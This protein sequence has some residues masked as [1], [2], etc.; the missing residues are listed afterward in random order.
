MADTIA[1]RPPPRRQWLADSA[2]K[3]TGTAVG[4]LALQETDVNEERDQLES[5]SDDDQDDDDEL[6]TQ[7]QAQTQSQTQTPRRSKAASGARQTRASNPISPA[8]TNPARESVTGSGSTRRGAAT[9]EDSAQESEDEDG[10]GATA[11]RRVRP[12]RG[13]KPAESSSEASDED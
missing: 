11:G 10:D 5:D 3:W 1:L 9:Q 12:K 8:R 7:T 2:G 6:N 4:L 13:K